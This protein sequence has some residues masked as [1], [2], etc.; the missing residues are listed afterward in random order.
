MRQTTTTH[1]KRRFP[2][3]TD[4]V[5]PRDR[6]DAYWA[7]NDVH[8]AIMVWIPMRRGIGAA[9]Q[10]INR[11]M[12]AAVLAIGKAANGPQP[13]AERGLERARDSIETTLIVLDNLAAQTDITE[14][15][16]DRA[17][18]RL[19]RLIA[20]LEELATLP[21]EE[22][23]KTSRPLEEWAWERSQVVDEA[24]AGEAREAA[25]EN[26]LRALLARRAA[27]VAALGRTADA[28]ALVSESSVTPS[29][30]PQ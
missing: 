15:V 2:F 21:V 17:R 12:S 16:R 18:G 26:P 7:A 4:M 28:T 29:P 8:S 14:D 19:V 25:I 30:S 1:T 11:A 6:V 22:W 20:R 5:F 23:G 27:E 13:R 10:R 24:A 9:R 3:T